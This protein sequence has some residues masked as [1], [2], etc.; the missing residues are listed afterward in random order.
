MGGHVSF[1]LNQP[2][3]DLSVPC[4]CFTVDVNG[5]LGNAMLCH[6][7]GELKTQAEKGIVIN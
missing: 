3:A 2:E 7:A 6:L 1:G 5:N 4:V